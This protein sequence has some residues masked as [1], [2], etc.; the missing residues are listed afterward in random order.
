MKMKDEDIKMLK[1]SVERANEKEIGV[2]EG[3]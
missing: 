2:P 3:T 1:L